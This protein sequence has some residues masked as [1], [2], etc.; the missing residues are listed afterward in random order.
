VHVGQ[1]ISTGLGHSD[2]LM[3]RQEMVNLLHEAASY[4]PNGIP[5][6]PPF[7]QNNLLLLRTRL[8][9][10]YYPND[11]VPDVRRDDIRALM[12][13]EIGRPID[14]ATLFDFSLQ[15]ILECDAAFSVLLTVN[16]L[17]SDE[18][19]FAIG[20]ANLDVIDRESLGT[21][22]QRAVD[23][24]QGIAAHHWGIDDNDLAIILPLFFGMLVDS[25]L[26]VPP[27]AW[28]RKR[29][30][31]PTEFDPAVKYFRLL[32]AFQ[33]LKGEAMDA[34]V[35]GLRQGTLVQAEAALLGAAKFAYPSSEE[36]YR[37][38]IDVLGPMSEE[39]AVA[40]IRRDACQFRLD[41]GVL[42]DRRDI[43]L[44]FGMQAPVMFFHTGRGFFKTDW[45]AR[46][47]DRDSEVSFV[48]ELIDDLLLVELCDF[49][50]RV[51][52]FR[53]PHARANICPSVRDECSA[54]FTT[55]EQFPEGE[56]C[57]ARDLLKFAHVV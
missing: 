9:Q 47:L 10:T 20:K 36:I 17:R 29:D 44:L 3:R 4:K 51:G 34:F 28:I 13:K 30:L 6:R 19:Q 23:Q 52:E 24:A 54:G 48:V 42:T 5:L 27:I 32:M 26:A 15:S 7:G 45:G 31:D 22:Y 12:G 46:V 11:E 41:N 53:C 43:D 35:R 14:D 2:F 38:W 16:Q 1:D 18:E 50:Y 37:A 55:F 40:K 49:I 57:R 25:A 39:S 8:R 33:Q 56:G 21:V